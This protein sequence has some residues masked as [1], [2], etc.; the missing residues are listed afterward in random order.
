MR[1]NVFI[2][3]PMSGFANY[4]MNAFME[5]HAELKKAGADLVF[6]PIL[7]WLNEPERVSQCRTHESY[8]LICL[9]ELTAYE[10]HQQNADAIVPKY[11]ILVHLDGWQNSPGSKTEV[12]VAEAVGIQTMDLQAACNLIRTRQIEAIERRPLPRYSPV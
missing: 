2:S 11:D 10:P 12:T 7:K 8:M 4:N 9:A 5:A 3:G 6:N 1:T